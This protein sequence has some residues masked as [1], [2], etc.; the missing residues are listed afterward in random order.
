M[1][2][3]EQYLSE[4]IQASEEYSTVVEGPYDR[5]RSQEAW[6]RLDQAQQAYRAALIDEA[7][8]LAAMQPSERWR[9]ALQEGTDQ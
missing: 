8:A 5:T 7:L 6:T 2:P 1:N 3:L 9:R 4:L